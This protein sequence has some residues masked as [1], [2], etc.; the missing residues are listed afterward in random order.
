MIK[1]PLKLDNSL[2]DIFLSFIL[3]F[4]DFAR[5]ITVFLVIPSKKES[6]IGVCNSSFSSLKKC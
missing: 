6:G 2:G 5:S 3:I 1:Q 4:F